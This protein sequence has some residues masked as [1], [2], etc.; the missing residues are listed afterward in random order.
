MRLLAF[1]L[2]LAV[3]IPIY[4]PL[5][6]SSSERFEQTHV[7]PY[8]DVFI[9]P[10]ERGDSPMPMLS[11][12]P[13]PGYYDTSEYMIGEVAV[14]VILPESDGSLDLDTEDWTPARQNEVRTEIETG[15]TWWAAQDSRARLNFVYQYNMSVP[16]KYE[17]INRPGYFDEGL[18]ISDVLNKSGYIGT[19]YFAQVMMWINDLRTN[20]DT[21]WAFAIFVVDSYNDADGSF[22]NGMSGYAYLGGPFVVMTYDNDGYGISGM[23]F[24]TAHETGHIFYATDEYN[25][26]PEYSGYLNVMDVEWSGCLMHQ[27]LSWC[28][29]SGTEG[30]V[31][32][33]DTD[34]D[35]IF[36]ILD[37]LPLTD[38]IP[39]SPDPTND[40]TPTYFGSATVVTYPNSNPNGPGN[41]ITISIVSQVEYAVDSSSWIVAQPSDGSF[42]GPT[43]AY[44][45]T[46]M[47]LSSGTHV[48]KARTNNSE[49]NTDLNPVEDEL[50]VDIELPISAL[51][52]FPSIVNYTLLPLTGT[53]SDDNGVVQ[54]ELWFSYESS[55]YEIWGN[56]TLA[57]WDWSVQTAAL[58]GDGNYSFYTIAIDIIGNRED[59]PIVPDVEVFVDTVVPV[60]IASAAAIVNTTIF[61]V[62]A[63]VWEQ[64]FI[65]RID[66]FYNCESLPWTYFGPRSSPPW[67]WTIDSTALCGDG[68]YRFYSQARDT[69][70]NIEPAPISADV[71][72]LVDTTPPVSGMQPLPQ[73]T[74]TSSFMVIATSYDLHGLSSIE[75]WV[76]FN[77]T[78]RQL[79]SIKSSPPWTA[80][81]DTLT[82]GGDGRYDFFAHAKDIA[83]NIEQTHASPD[84][85]TLVDTVPPIASINPLPQYLN[86]FE[87]AIGSVAS[88]LNGVSDVE[89]WYRKDGGGWVLHSTKSV[90]PWSWMFNASS[91][92]EGFYE[93]SSV[94]ID[95][96]GN[97][98]SGGL[99]VEATTTVDVT[100]PNIEILSPGSGIWINSSTVMLSW[101]GYDIISEI[102]EYNL[103]VDARN[104]TL[105]NLETQRVVDGLSDGHHLTN[106]RAWDMAGNSALTIIELLI[107]VTPPIV[108]ISYPGY[109]D[110]V[111]SSITARWIGSDATSGLVEYE[112]SLDG[113]PFLDVVLSTQIDLNLNPG[114]H[115][116]T[117]R[118][119]DLAGNHADSTVEFTA[120]APATGFEGLIVIIFIGLAL[121]IA[122]IVVVILVLQK[123]RKKEDE[124]LPPPPS[125]D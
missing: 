89:L 71:I 74:N 59:P 15:L 51:N 124:E 81:V 2:S 35:G 98:E 115:V 20:L 36:D 16:T 30:Q 110:S 109:N 10:W 58:D 22:S 57:P 41:N 44:R 80:N 34:G 85:T 95:T 78:G 11:A 14:G 37:E 77:Q 113:G 31:G 117:I 116:L 118:A 7:F 1:L 123:K 86:T 72:V 17:P 25:G 21:D 92:G 46:T 79:L 101:S 56:D 105:S 102:S 9:R 112:Y 108:Q 32:W 52:S 43:E 84:A 60:S 28:L 122:T 125:A 69:A 49:G 53:A 19:D 103:Q 42:D 55:A 3:V 87:F 120:I 114:A 48:I 91:I 75:I 38:L 8:D 73:Y 67:L 65:L 96:A 107:D 66:L 119:W 104:W 100:P 121:L 83:G 111:S 33:R 13:A 90:E 68:T 12:P 94:A 64:G 27:P 54:V 40:S 99:A 26:N 23:D 39:Y 93:F 106:L 24:V 88:D 50:T 6:P 18:W 5:H 82:L 63:N 47:P 70:G 45:F 62:T 61:D 29:S 4:T 76:D 97:R